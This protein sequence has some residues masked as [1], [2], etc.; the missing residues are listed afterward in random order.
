[1]RYTCHPV[2]EIDYHAETL[3]KHHHIGLG[4]CVPLHDWPFLIRKEWRHLEEG[5]VELHH[6]SITVLSSHIVRRPLHNLDI[7]NSEVGFGE[8]HKY[9]FSG[10]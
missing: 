4:K 6:L 5:V 7:H 2:D 8:E 9:T 3:P 10:S 1:M